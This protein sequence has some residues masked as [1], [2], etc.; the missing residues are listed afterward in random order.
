MR[1]MMMGNRVFL[2]NNKTSP[3]LDIRI[4]WGQYV[5]VDFLHSDPF[6]AGGL[7]VTLGA[8]DI[9]VMYEGYMLQKKHEVRMKCVCVT[10][11]YNLRKNL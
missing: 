7:G 10:M 4:G 6:L 8:L 1:A 11:A 2:C 5:T 9:G 3:F